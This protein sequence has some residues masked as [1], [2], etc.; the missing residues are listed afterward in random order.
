MKATDFEKL[1]SEITGKKIT[2]WL[3]KDQTAKKYYE[4][5]YIKFDTIQENTIYGISVESNTIDFDLKVGKI[6]NLLKTF[7]TQ[8]LN[9]YV[10]GSI[11][12]APNGDFMKHTKETAISTLHN[13]SVRN[14]YLLCYSTNY[15]IG[16][17]NIFVS[18]KVFNDLVELIK[19]QLVSEDISYNNE[20]SEAHWVYRFKFSGGA[21]DHNLMVE[22]LKLFVKVLGD[23]SR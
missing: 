14:A 16:V 13:L 21:L 8:Y 9:K 3:L 6:E 23:S 10:V 17:W 4:K 20:Y 19:K 11:Y 18:K 22:K 7:V 2:I 1:A 12:F 15:G 5:S